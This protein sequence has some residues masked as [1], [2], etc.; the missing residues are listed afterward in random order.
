MGNKGNRGIRENGRP[1]MK[2]AHA[3]RISW[4]RLRT[5]VGIRKTEKKAKNG[6]KNKRALSVLCVFA[7]AYKKHS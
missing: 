6:E 7:R 5:E 3:V 4:G 1:P 2:Y